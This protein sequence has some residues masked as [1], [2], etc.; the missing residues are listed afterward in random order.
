MDLRFK[1]KLNVELLF[2]LEEE[3]KPLSI[4]FIERSSVFIIEVYAITRALIEAQ[5]LGH[6]IHIYKDLIYVLISLESIRLNVESSVFMVEA[7][8]I[9]RA[10]IE[11]QGLGDSIH[12]YADSMSVFK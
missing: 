4:R 1:V 11:A 2:K 5:G 6:S 9:K 10:F 8:A 12:I 7:Y 3:I